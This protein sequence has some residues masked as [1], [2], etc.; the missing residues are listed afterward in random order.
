MV[1]LLQRFRD[2]DMPQSTLWI[3]KEGDRGLASF[4]GRSVSI[5]PGLEPCFP[6]GGQ[7]MVSATFAPSASRLV[8][9][10]LFVQEGFLG[11]WYAAAQCKLQSSS[12]RSRSYLEKVRKSVSSKGC[13]VLKEVCLVLA[14]KYLQ[15]GK[16][17][18][19][20]QQAQVGSLA[21][22]RHVFHCSGLGLW[23]SR[24]KWAFLGV[25]V[26]AV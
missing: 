24:E 17:G 8:T 5:R 25:F 6:S 19:S 26:A 13:D 16:V 1:L 15:E 2:F 20:Q 14:W 12:R 7:L 10:E 18:K 3:N 9:G 21:G 4:C 11:H 23:K 22:R